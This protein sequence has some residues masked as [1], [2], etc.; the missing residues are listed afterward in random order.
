M[1]AAIGVHLR[2]DPLRRAAERELAQRGEVPFAKEALGGRARDLGDVNFPLAQPLEE[3]V[4]RQIDQLHLVGLVEHGVGDRLAHRNPGDLLDD[5]VQ[6]LQ[7][8]DIERREDVEPRVEQRLHVL[9]SFGMA[10]AGMLVC[11]SSST[12]RIAGRRASA[13]ARSEFL[14]RGAA[15]LGLLRREDLEPK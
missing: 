12:M 2:V 5:V 13:A 4:G 7:M 8:L 3:R 9:V 11:A 1:L 14:E 15:I 10:R 6:T